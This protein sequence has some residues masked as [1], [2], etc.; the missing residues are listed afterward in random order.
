MATQY[1]PSISFVSLR[2]TILAFS[3]AK[4][5]DELFRD[6]LQHHK[7]K[8]HLAL[9]EKL[10]HPNSI[11]DGDVLAACA[12]TAI[13]F[14]EVYG[15]EAIIHANGC[16]AMLTCMY[17]T[18]KSSTSSDML[19]VF[20]P[21]VSDYANFFTAFGS[22]MERSPANTEPFTRRRTL[23]QQ[24]VKYWDA[25]KRFGF[26]SEAPQASG[27]IEAV[28]E[29]FGDMIDMLTCCIHRLALKQTMQDFE[30][31]KI[32][33]DFLDQVAAELND[34]EL[35]HA[36]DLL[37]SFEVHESLY[38]VFQMGCLDLVLTILRDP[39]IMH[40]IE[41]AE[42]TSMAKAIVYRHRS[43]VKEVGPSREYYT[44]PYQ[45]GLVVVGVA[46]PRE[47]I[48]DCKCPLPHL[49]N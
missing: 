24:R 30:R 13:L 18:A 37:K 34:F 43:Q 32:V 42:T 8:A 1:G 6:R 33:D 25:L 45:R 12:L 46:L 3:A 26:P 9:L 16:Q 14:A 28:G 39:S 5:P 35:Q 15:T 48:D 23:F 17:E 7:N 21:Y 38:E 11:G 29:V 49:L 10:E 44:N 41:S 27:L 19:D 47:E 40:G 36:I 2:H 20:G 4:L 31:D 22:L